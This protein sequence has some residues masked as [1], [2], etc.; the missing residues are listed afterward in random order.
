MKVRKMY[1]FG[2]PWLLWNCQLLLWD[3]ISYLIIFLRINKNKQNKQSCG[4][5]NYNDQ[6][7]N[8]V[9]VEFEF[10]IKST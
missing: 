3:N 2:E 7:N 1:I 10:I 4:Q 8:L 5:S 9:L 6:I